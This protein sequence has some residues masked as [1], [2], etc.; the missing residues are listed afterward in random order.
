MGIVQQREEREEENCVT[1][2][3]QAKEER[4]VELEGCAADR[5]AFQGDGVGAVEDGGEEGEGVAEEELG[6]GLGREGVRYGRGPCR[7]GCVSAGT[8][9]CSGEVGVGDEDDADE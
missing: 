1:Q 4:H 6:S 8:I 3:N 7:R 5:G 9:W 2:P